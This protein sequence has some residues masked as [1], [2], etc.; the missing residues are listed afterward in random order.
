[1][2]KII[3]ILLF[4]ALFFIETFLNSIIFYSL[5]RLG[6]NIDSIYLRLIITVISWIV[7]MIF[8]FL[9]Y[10]KSLIEEFKLYK[11]NFK[12]FFIFGLK[13]WFISLSMMVISNILIS[14]VYS[15]NSVNEEVVQSFL[16]KYPIYTTISTL[17]YAP[18]VEEIIFRKSLR[19]IFNNKA[20]Y[21]LISGLI[22]GLCHVVAGI[23]NTMELLYLIPYG[24]MGA[25]FAYIYSKTNSIF[26]S[27]SM[28]FIH[29]LI[30][31]IIST[32][33]YIIGGLV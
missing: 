2:K 32:L 24:I 20:L 5:Y 9:V 3:N 7:F 18:F 30:T 19:G 10:R 8:I 4:V 6:I 26:V 16:V 13:V 21:I 12:S 27:M 31:L 15:S 23:D 29:N 25:S 1:M 14:F 22:F 28:H 33:P 17:I 11:D